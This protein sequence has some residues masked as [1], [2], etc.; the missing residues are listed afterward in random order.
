MRM[1]MMMIMMIVV[2]TAGETVVYIQHKSTR[3]VC[4]CV[5]WA[6]AMGLIGVGGQREEL[7]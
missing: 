4:V 1:M 7:G 2:C 5:C 6:H 3:F